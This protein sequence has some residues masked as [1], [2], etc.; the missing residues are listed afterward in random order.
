M[1]YAMFAA[2]EPYR[3]AIVFEQ[4]SIPHACLP[5]TNA[6]ELPT[7]S[8]I[9]TIRWD[10]CFRSYTVA[11][12]N[13]FPEKRFD[14][15]LTSTKAAQ[16]PNIVTDPSATIGSFYD[17]WYTM[18]MLLP[19]LSL[20]RRI[21]MMFAPPGCVC[22]LLQLLGKDTSNTICR[23]EPWVVQMRGFQYN[24]MMRGHGKWS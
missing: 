13:M 3:N 23:V 5:E 9:S 4:L 17:G 22:R 7:G 6:S 21:G 14:C 10:I 15:L 20:I 11:W 2:G 24:K 18:I 8:T 16:H 12:S 1:V 19:M